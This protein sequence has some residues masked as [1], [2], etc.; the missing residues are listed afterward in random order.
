MAR[1]NLRPALLVSETGKMRGTIRQ[2]RDGADRAL[3]CAVLD[4][5][6]VGFALDALCF[7]RLNFDFFEPAGSLLSDALKENT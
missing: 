3:L 1:G 4:W 6:N 7:T 5:F 2:N